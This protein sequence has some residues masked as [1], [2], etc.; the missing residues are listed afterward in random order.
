MR[1]VQRDVEEESTHISGLI[2]TDNKIKQ[3]HN[4]VICATINVQ[5]YQGFYS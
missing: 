2:E 1:P 3:V 4:F 5:S